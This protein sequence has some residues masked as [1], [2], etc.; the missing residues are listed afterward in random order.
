MSEKIEVTASYTRKINHALY[1][2]GDYENSDHFCSMKTETEADPSQ[3]Y[4]ELHSACVDNV[5]HSIAKEVANFTE[6]M[7]PRKFV[8]L[9]R[10]YRL[11]NIQIVDTT[12]EEMDLVQKNI[13]EEFKKLKRKNA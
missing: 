13:L 12:V 8:E 3:V 2:G 1:G 11:D 9:L 4:E 10:Q 7:T 6:G 5:N